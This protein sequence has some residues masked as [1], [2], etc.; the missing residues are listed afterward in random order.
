MSQDAKPQQLKRTVMIAAA[1]LIMILV[2]NLTPPEGLP[3][4]GMQVV[5][6]FLGVLLLWLGISIE[7]PSLLCIAA[8]AFVPGLKLSSILSGSL[9][10]ST[11][12]F[13]LF[14]FLCTHA[15]SK[16][17]FIRR[18][19]LAFVDCKIARKGMWQ[20]CIFFFASVLFLGSFI[21][22]T[23]LFVVYLPILEEIYTVL[24][25][26]KGDKTASMLMMGLV[27]TC[28]ISSGMTPIAHV[29]P[30]MAIGY[31]NTATGLSISYAAYM[32]FAIPVGL[33]VSLLMLMMFRFLLRPDMASV[34]KFDVGAM[35]KPD[36][37]DSREKT[38]LFV[39][40][41]V[42]ALWVLPGL[43]K[44]V[45]PAAAAYIDS[46][47]TAMPPLLGAVALSILTKDGA[48]L[49]DFKNA[50][51]NGV[52]WGSLIMCA[53]TL[54]LGA[55]MTND[56]I[57]LKLWLSDKVAPLTAQLSVFAIVLLFTFWAAL[58]TNLSSN[59]VTVTVVC[60]VAIP[61]CLSTNGAVNTAAIASI[62]G[63]MASYA[64]A[65]P[66][67]MPCVAIAG[68]S[69]W[70]TAGSLLRYGFLLMVLSVLAAVLIGYPLASALMPSAAI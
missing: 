11:F 61:F 16:T 1:L 18:C 15:L 38:I 29:F 60:A 41:L 5:G 13:L 30:Q 59:M 19:A 47:G 65:T 23:V 67:A 40:F 58:Q 32:G 17:P 9:G 21:S 25:L 55:A 27:F 39:F 45:F 28:G 48:P 24:G 12:A 49:L 6:I 63:M 52:P 50:M 46:F 31:Y 7:W 34:R 57:G 10:N 20:F 22:P 2:G 36:R 42:I 64:F 33:L 56:D 4:A 70:T 14:T 66:P 51:A 8:L 54:A 53:S 62:I 26:Q 44:P 43:I 69:G 68:A 35:E 37:M 3:Q